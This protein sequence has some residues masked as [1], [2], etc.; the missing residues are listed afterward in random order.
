[1]HSALLGM[2]VGIA[3]EVFVYVKQSWCE[4]CV[5]FTV[6]CWHWLSTVFTLVPYKVFWCHSV[7][8]TNVSENT[9]VQYWLGPAGASW[10]RCDL[11]FATVHNMSTVTKAACHCYVVTN[12]WIATVQINESLTAGSVFCYVHTIFLCSSFSLVL[13][14]GAADCSTVSV[15][16]Y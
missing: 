1:M 15:S 9:L 5:A 7:M 3:V 11:Y 14:M 16:A 13:K 4:T 2:W 8:T 12:E 6:L 10:G